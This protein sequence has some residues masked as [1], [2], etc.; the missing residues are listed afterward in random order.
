MLKV[1]TL[2]FISLAALGRLYARYP[3]LALAA[4]GDIQW[5]ERFGLRGVKAL[6]A[7]LNADRTRKAA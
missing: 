7:R 1:L 3:N 5:I 2:S 6:P 4:P